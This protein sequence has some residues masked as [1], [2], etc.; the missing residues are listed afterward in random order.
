MHGNIDFATEQ[1]L[2]DLLGEQ[3]FA[4]KVAKRLVPD[5]IARGGDDTERDAVLFEAM[6]VDQKGPHMTGLPKGEGT[7]SGADQEPAI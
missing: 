3:P 2:V 1:S 6:G 7:S 4:A 5:A